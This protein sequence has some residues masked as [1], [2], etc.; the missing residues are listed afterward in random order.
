[1]SIEV[2]FLI[3]YFVAMA[4]IGLWSVRAGSKDEEGFLLGGDDPGHGLERASGR[5]GA[6]GR[7]NRSAVVCRRGGPWRGLTRRI[8]GIGCCWRASAAG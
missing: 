8:F 4:G 7:R 1:M 2:V 5:L 6:F 3:I